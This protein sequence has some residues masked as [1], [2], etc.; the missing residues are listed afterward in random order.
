M[1]CGEELMIFRE[2]EEDFLG[3]GEGL[4]WIFFKEE[5]DESECN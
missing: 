3:E 5:E 4:V 1:E 2:E